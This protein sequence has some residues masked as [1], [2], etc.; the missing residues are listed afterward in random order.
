MEKLLK[1]QLNKIIAIY[2]E[3]IKKRGSGMEQYN[4]Q[5]NNNK[6]SS[7]KYFQAKNH[8]FQEKKTASRFHHCKRHCLAY[9][10]T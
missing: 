8:C 3:N 10:S 5:G 1:L 6:N 2:E 7:E 9:T 4:L